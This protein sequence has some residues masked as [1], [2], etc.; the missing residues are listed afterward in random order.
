MASAYQPPAWVDL[1]PQPYGRVLN[2]MALAMVRRQRQRGADVGVKTVMEAI[3]ATF[4]ASSGCDPYDGEPLDAG[5]LAAA[6]P[7]LPSGRRDDAAHLRRQPALVMVGNGQLCAYELVSR[8]T[9]Q[10]KGDLTPAE[11]IAHCR[12]VVAMAGTDREAATTA[13]A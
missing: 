9:A 13:S 8:Q 11:Y 6:E 4:H 7:C 12:A 3:H 5:L 2:R 10:A 1:D